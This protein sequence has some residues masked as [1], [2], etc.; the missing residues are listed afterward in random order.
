MF[1]KLL[2]TKMAVELTDNADPDM[3]G[4]LSNLGSVQRTRV[5]LLG[6]LS[7]L[8]G[9]MSNQAIAVELGWL[10]PEQSRLSLETWE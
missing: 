6:D 2:N 7:D 1:E 4:Y 9:P 5:K 3:P 8:E 10:P